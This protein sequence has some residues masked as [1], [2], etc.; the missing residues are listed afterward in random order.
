M[1]ERKLICESKF[2]KV[3]LDGDKYIIEKLGRNGAVLG[4]TDFKVKDDPTLPYKCYKD[5]GYQIV[6]MAYVS[7]IYDKYIKGKNVQTAYD[8]V[9]E[10]KKLE[11]EEATKE[12]KSKK[13]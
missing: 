10:Q 3:Y 11:K 12:S 1:A 13:K 5:S 6:D 9:R 7:D 2:G 8:K 4:S